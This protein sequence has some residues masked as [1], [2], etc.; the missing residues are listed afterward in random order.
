MNSFARRVLTVLLLALLTAHPPVN[1]D[2]DL[3]SEISPEFDSDAFEW[4]YGQVI[5]SITVSGNVKTSSIAL[6]REMELRVGDQLDPVKL[7]RDHRYLTD[8][9]S[10]ATVGVKVYPIREGHCGLNINVTERPTIFLKL[11]YPI[12]EYNFN[13]NRFRYGLR[14]NNRNFRK[15]LESLSAGYTRNSINDESANVGWQTRWIGWKHVGVGTWARYF[16]RGPQQERLSILEQASLT[17]ALSLPL[18]DSRM[19]FAQAIGSLTFAKNRLGYVGVESQ[20]EWLISPSLGFSIDRR[21][22]P[23]RPTGG[24]VFWVDVQ[25]NRVVNGNGSTYYL[26]RN[27]IRLF[28]SASSWLVFGGRSA[29]AYQFGEFPEYLRYGLGGVGTIRGFSNGV[30]EGNHRWIQSFEAR[31]SP[32]PTWIFNVPYAKMIDVT[33]STVLFVDTGIA[34]Y[35]ERDFNRSRWHSGFGFGLRIFSPF[36]DVVRLDLG[37]NKQGAKYF[38]FGTGMV[39]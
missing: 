9:S 19:S 30:F 38:Y 35:S 20:D 34:W 32:L 26:L 1:A 10:I 6:L 12:V 37:F 17:T 24:G 28:R 29:L 7:K 39:F 36:Q 22:S 11:I 27:D 8:V 25:S 3:A 15:R 23:L 33:V 21:D 18:T 16:K 5:D 31:I 2:S 4:A 14:V 13:T